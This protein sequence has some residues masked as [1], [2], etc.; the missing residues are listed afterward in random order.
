MSGIVFSGIQ[1]SPYVVYR[2][3][4]FADHDTDIVQNSNTP[5]FN[6][7]KTCPVPMTTELDT[8]LRATVRYLYSVNC[9]Q[10]VSS[11]FWV[12][13]QRLRRNG[14]RDE[15]LE[16][17][18]GS[19]RSTKIIFAQGKIKLKKKNSCSPINPKKNP[20]NGLKKIH[21]RNLITKKNS[22][23]SKILSSPPPLH[24]FSN[25][26]S[27]KGKGYLCSSPIFLQGTET[28]VSPFGDACSGVFILL[29]EFFCQKGLI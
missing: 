29:K 21:T 11:D 19:G 13:A 16:N 7:A 24:N 17:L 18:W 25:G 27:L 3:F 8:Y 6:D 22:C 10:P 28:L 9:L 15:P 26:P 2:F 5:E 14:L 23:G 1:P 12:V 4:D 20:C